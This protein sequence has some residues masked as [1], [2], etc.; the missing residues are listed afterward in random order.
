TRDPDG[1]LG[2]S[3]THTPPPLQVPVGQV[4]AALARSQESVQQGP[5]ASSHSS[6][7]STTPA[8]HT[9]PADGSAIE[10]AICAAVFGQLDSFTSSIAPRSHPV[11]IGSRETPIR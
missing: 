5:A 6:G 7:P 10:R 4:S 3:G 2:A 11:A 1:V 9:A 8:P